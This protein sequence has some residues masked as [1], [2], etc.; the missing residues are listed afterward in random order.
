LLK[1]CNGFPAE[2]IPEQRLARGN[3]FSLSGGS[4]TRR[5][6]YPLPEADGPGIHPTLDQAA[7][8][9]LA[10][11][12][13]WIKHRDY[14]VNITRLPQFEEVIRRYWP[15]LDADRL[16]PAYAG[17]RPKLFMEGEPYRDFLIQGEKEHGIKGMINLLGIESPGLTAALAIAEDIANLG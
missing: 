13:E 9:R 6:V 4:P 16:T 5:L 14:Q 10:P 17:I 2:K 15:S 1:D 11:D 12:V 8:P 7:N 3:Y